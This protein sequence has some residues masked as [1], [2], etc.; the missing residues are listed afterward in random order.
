MTAPIIELDTRE[1]DRALRGLERQAPFVLAVSLT[2]TVQ[3]VQA[4]LRK[5]LPT[6]FT[7]RDG[8]VSKGIRIKAAKKN[9]P[10]AEVGSKDE[11]M[12]EQAEGATVAGA[13]ATKH[14]RKTTK[15]RLRASVLPVALARKAARLRILTKPDGSFRFPTDNTPAIMQRVK[16]SRYPLRRLYTF[17]KDIEIPERWPFGATVEEI[18]TK[19]WPEEVAKAIRRV[20][21]EAR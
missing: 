9:D 21:D 13:I 20:L 14:I 17:S 10:E 11:F 12:R 15:T 16:K 19:V 1:V 18:A 3:A 6:Q 4:E 2:R 5:D 8:W 7:I